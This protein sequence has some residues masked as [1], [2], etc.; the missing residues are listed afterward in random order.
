LQGSWNASINNM[1]IFDW[2]KNLTKPPE[3]YLNVVDIKAVSTTLSNGGQ[4][5]FELVGESNYQTRIYSMLPD[6][7]TDQA[8][9]RAYFVGKINL[10][11]D[12]EYDNKAVNFAIDNRVVGY[13]A[14]D[15][16]RKFRKMIVKNNLN[17]NNLTCRSVVVGG[18]GKNYGIWLEIN[19]N[20]SF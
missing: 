13:F 4:Y 2:F 14:R 20:G 8:Q 3:C 19:L 15:D 10:E 6:S 18:K 17:Q 1:G 12:N 7:V 11:D 16:A 9:Q 5:D